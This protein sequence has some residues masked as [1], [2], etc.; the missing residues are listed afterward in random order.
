MKKIKATLLEPDIRKIIYDGHVIKIDFNRKI[1]I[2]GYIPIMVQTSLKNKKIK[3]MTGVIDENL[4]VIVP[5]RE[6]VVSKSDFEKENF[7]INISIYE[8]SKALY[9]TKDAVYLINLKTVRFKKEEDDYIPNGYYFKFKSVKEIGNGKI[10]V[11]LE[12][13]SFVYDVI[14]NKIDSLI[15]NFIKPSINHKGY[16]DAFFEKTNDNVSPLL[17]HFIIDNNFWISQEAFLNE[18]VLAVVPS[19]ANTKQEIL[20][21]CDDCYNTYCGFLEEGLCKVL[22]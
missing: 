5:I 7:S 11:Y 19:F 2:D 14:N 3:I 16:Y 18:E 13:K 8:G 9:E 20:K 1:S 12:N 6:K 15:F 22:Q 17:I 4:N 10:I 21:Y